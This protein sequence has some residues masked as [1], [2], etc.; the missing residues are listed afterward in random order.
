[1]PIRLANWKPN[2]C[3]GDIATDH[4]AV[5]ESVIDPNICADGRS[6]NTAFCT[7]VCCT[8]GTAD[9][10]SNV[11]P[12]IPP[13]WKPNECPDDRAT[14]FSTVNESVIDS[15]ICAVGGPNGAAF[16]TAVCLTNGN[17]D[18]SSNFV[19]HHCEPVDSANR[20]PKCSA[21]C[22]T[23]TI[24]FHVGERYVPHRCGL[25]TVSH[26]RDVQCKSVCTQP[27]WH[28]AGIWSIGVRLTSNDFPVPDFVPNALHQQLVAQHCAVHSFART[29][30]LCV[31]NGADN[32]ANRCAVAIAIVH[33][34][35]ISHCRS[36]LST[37]SGA[38]SFTN[39][40]AH[41][42]S[43]GKTNR[44]PNARSDAGTKWVPSRRAN[45]FTKCDPHRNTVAATL[46]PTNGGAN[47]RTDGT[48]CTGTNTASYRCAVLESLISAHGHPYLGTDYNTVD[49]SYRTA[50]D[51]ANPCT[52][53]T[54]ISG[55][56]KRAANCST[57]GLALVC[58]DDS[59]HHIANSK[60][61][62]GADSRT[63][64]DAESCAI[65]C[66]NVRPHPPSHAICCPNHSADGGAN[67]R[68]DYPWKPA[69][70]KPSDP[71]ERV[72][73][74]AQF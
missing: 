31:T 67:H 51:D 4:S 62:C 1:M 15:N 12:H 37:I 66:A 6:N 5:E 57:D 8:N 14:D 47:I 44:C 10:S 38:V 48:A 42:L 61:N 20:R 41:N 72:Y 68:L 45:G 53:G 21:D 59:A 27:E 50:N 55:T 26:R 18:E 58:A 2:E 34:N 40:V 33:T 65:Y 35:T 13:N 74:G 22:P 17:T 49:E 19:P 73:W 71:I 60:P 52:I 64:S 23:D 3:P 56:T 16:R 70:S 30:V 54:A 46:S 69:E 39:S 25:T 24:V 9:E 11:V 36:N 7:A 63:N 29:A 28:T 32:G 43:I